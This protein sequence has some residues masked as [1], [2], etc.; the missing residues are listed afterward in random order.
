MSGRH[1]QKSSVSPPDVWDRSWETYPY[2]TLD[3]SAFFRR[4]FRT[5]LAFSKFSNIRGVH[6]SSNFESSGRTIQNPGET[7]FQV[8]LISG[9]YLGVAFDISRDV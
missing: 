9:R 8:F 3:C 6:M 4:D 1:L 2:V 5:R 7:A